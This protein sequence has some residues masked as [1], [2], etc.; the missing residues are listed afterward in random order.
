MTSNLKIIKK[1]K[2]KLRLKVIIT[3]IAFLVFRAIISDWEHFKA[4]I[5]GGF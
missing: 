2:N 5:T 4:G 1:E 3:V